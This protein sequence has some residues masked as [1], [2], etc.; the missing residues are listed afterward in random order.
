MIYPGCQPDTPQT[1]FGP[2]HYKNHDACLMHSHSKLRLMPGFWSTRQTQGFT[3]LHLT[4]YFKTVRFTSRP[5]YR[6]YIYSGIYI[7]TEIVEV[8]WVRES[9][10]SNSHVPCPGLT[11]LSPGLAHFAPL[12]SLALAWPYL[13][14]HRTHKKVLICIYISWQTYLFC[15]DNGWKPD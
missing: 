1:W 9:G 15:Q 7:F 3:N 12:K 13:S 8:G 2:P 10:L 6:T 14:F 11:N 4:E 5:V